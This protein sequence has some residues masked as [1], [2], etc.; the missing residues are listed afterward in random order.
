M[1]LPL[2]IIHDALQND[3]LVRK[4]MPLSPGQVSVLRLVKAAGKAQDL[5]HV[6]E[7]T[8]IS[9]FSDEDRTAQ[10]KHQERD[11]QA[12]SWDYIAQ[13]KAEILL[14]VGHPSQ[15]QNGPQVD[16]PVEPVEEPARRLWS[17]VFNLQTQKARSVKHVTVKQTVYKIDIIWI[18]TPFFFLLQAWFSL[19]LEIK[20]FSIK[21]STCLYASLGISKA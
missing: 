9:G 21:S 4:Y 15:R 1:N 19:N 7:G 11:P 17:S 8:A 12:H 3:V 20:R 6:C 2:V 14:D 13:L 5:E 18:E 10:E 16:A